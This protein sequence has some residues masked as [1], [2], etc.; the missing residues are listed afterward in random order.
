MKATGLLAL[1]V[2]GS[3]ALSAQSLSL[4]YNG[5]PIPPNYQLT[6]PGHPNAGDMIVEV[7][8]TNN[9]LEDLLILVKKV[10]NYLVPNTQNTFCWAGM[11]YA[12]NVYVSPFY[13]TIYA[14]QTTLPGEFSGHYNALSNPGQSSISYVFFDMNNPND[15]VMVTIIYDATLTG[16]PESRV[17]SVSEPYPN[18]ANQNVRFDYF[19]DEPVLA[20]LKVYSLLGTLVN[21]TKLATGEGTINVETSGIGE[22]FYFYVLTVDRKEIKTG[23]FVVRH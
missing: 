5:N 4:V 16:I 14:G 1:L 3:V 8:V 15:S 22:G 13:D 9:S 19:I 20:E 18:P 21:E 12:P 6:V 10:E 2:F 7:E 11:C 23:R 17:A